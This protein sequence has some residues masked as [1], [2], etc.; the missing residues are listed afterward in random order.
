MPSYV[1]RGTLTL[2]LTHTHTRAQWDAIDKRHFFT[3]SALIQEI[4]LRLSTSLVFELMCVYFTLIGNRHQLDFTCRI[5]ILIIQRA[6]REG[7]I[8]CSKKCV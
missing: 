7:S 1:S 6:K 3:F 8:E 5:S 2:T 4:K